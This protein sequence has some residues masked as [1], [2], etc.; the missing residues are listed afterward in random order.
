MRQIVVMLPK[1]KEDLFSY[2]INWA[3]YDKYIWASVEHER[4]AFKR[5]LRSWL[6]SKKMLN[7]WFVTSCQVSKIMHVP[8]SRLVERLQ[9]ILGDG[10][11]VFVRRMW[12][13]LIFGTK[14]MLL[15]LRWMTKSS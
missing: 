4:M 11:E 1:T 14:L 3:V 10:S 2:E 15:H 13:R 9:L 6:G 5:K 7:W 12:Q 8:A